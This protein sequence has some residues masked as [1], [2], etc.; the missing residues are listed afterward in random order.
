MFDQIFV[1]IG[2]VV[3][4]ACLAILAMLFIDLVRDGCAALQSWTSSPTL[5]R[6]MPNAPAFWLRGWARRW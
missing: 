6:A 1:V 5:L 3:M 4:L 2:L